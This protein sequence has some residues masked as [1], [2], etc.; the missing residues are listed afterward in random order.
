MTP[1]ANGLMCIAFLSSV[2]MSYNATNEVY[3]LDRIDT[4]ELTKFVTKRNV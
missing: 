4:K 3:T 2:N 1:I